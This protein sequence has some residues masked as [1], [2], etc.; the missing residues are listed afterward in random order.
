[1]IGVL[2]FP[3]ALLPRS[4]LKKRDQNILKTTNTA[5]CLI[6]NFC[7][8][9]RGMNFKSKNNKR[10]SMNIEEIFFFFFRLSDY[11]SGNLF[12]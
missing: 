3:K 1:M 5:F 9:Q 11:M 2:A 4:R 6:Q 8:K 12:Q 7:S 10:K